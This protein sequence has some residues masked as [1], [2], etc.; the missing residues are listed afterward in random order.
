MVELTGV[1]ERLREGETF[2]VTVTGE[3]LH[4]LVVPVIV[5]T[6]VLVGLTVLVAPDPEGNQ[7]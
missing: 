6:V 2:T 3:L 7:L 4:P 1:R 5:Y